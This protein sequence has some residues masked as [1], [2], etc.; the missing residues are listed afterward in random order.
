LVVSRGAVV[1]A[2]FA[3]RARRR[4]PFAFDVSA[5]CDAL[6]R[7]WLELQSAAEPSWLQVRRV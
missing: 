7:G 6:V 2:A 4:C 3:L 1:L 5:C